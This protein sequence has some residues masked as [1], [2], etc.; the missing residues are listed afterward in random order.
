MTVMA[1]PITVLANMARK[2]ASDPTASNSQPDI[3]QNEVKTITIEVDKVRLDRFLA[4]QFPE[5]SRSSL[6]RWIKD[7]LISSTPP[8]KLKASTKLSHGIQ[9]HIAIPPEPPPAPVLCPQDIDIPLLYQDEH[10]LIVNKPPG[11]IV[12]PGPGTPDG[13]LVNALLA[14]GGPLSSAGGE[15]RPGIVHRLDKDTSGVMV[16]ARNDKAHRMIS[17]QFKERKTSKMYRAIVRGDTP[18]RGTIDKPLG[19]HLKDRKK[20]AVRYDGGR[21]SVSHFEVKERLGHIA[22]FVDIRIE[23]GRTH[24]IRVHMSSIGHGVLADQTYGRSRHTA[25]EATISRQALHAAILSFDHPAT[26]ERVTF[27]APLP[28]DMTNALIAL[29]ALNKSKK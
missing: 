15:E 20:Q 28:D 17:A 19:R 4:S 10:I 22:T 13:T 23:T 6:Q 7:Q 24:Q 21:H 12:H 11:L 14:L 2:Q 27:E 25:A 9:I 8:Q 5:Q 29:R 3:S 16:V 1:S 18:D 26:N